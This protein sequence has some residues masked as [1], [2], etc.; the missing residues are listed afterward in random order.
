MDE[1]YGIAG[2]TAA[3]FQRNAITPLIALVLL[4]AGVDRKSVV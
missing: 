3:A 2:R 1:R 4:L